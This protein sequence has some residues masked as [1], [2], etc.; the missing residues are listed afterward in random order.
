VRSLAQLDVRAPL[1]A[2]LAVEQDPSVWALLVKKLA[3]QP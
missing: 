2:R 3:K 1:E